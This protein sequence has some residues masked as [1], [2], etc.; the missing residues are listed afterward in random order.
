MEPWRPAFLG[1]EPWSPKP[2]WDPDCWIESV[3][4]KILHSDRKNIL[5]Y[6]A[7]FSF[8][9]EFHDKS[10]ESDKNRETPCL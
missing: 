4:R 9:S 5:R 1:P 6:K 3:K 2:L 10:G 7:L 8:F